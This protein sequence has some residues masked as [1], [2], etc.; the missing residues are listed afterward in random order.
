M[1]FPKFEIISFAFLSTQELLS[2][3]FGGESRIRRNRIDNGVIGFPS[4]K[5]LWF[6]CSEPLL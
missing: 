3:I 1:L 6:R 5:S 2:K 4:K